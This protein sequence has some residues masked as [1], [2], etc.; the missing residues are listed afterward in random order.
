MFTNL[1]IQKESGLT[2]SK[3]IV[4]LSAR[5]MNYAY[6]IALPLT[7]QGCDPSAVGSCW[8][9][10]MKCSLYCKCCFSSSEM[11]LIFEYDF[12]LIY[13]QYKRNSDLC[14]NRR[15]YAKGEEKSHRITESLRFEKTLRIIKSTHN[16]TRSMVCNY[17][18]CWMYWSVLV[19]AVIK[20][21]QGNS[22]SVC[23]KDGSSCIVCCLLPFFFFFSFFK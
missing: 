3:H 15:K 20:V 14:K 22:P 8:S 9:T 19:S 23:L 2:A 1:I 16:L 4:M 21:P 13:C 12:F 6:L 5:T 10:Q 7:K 18:V 11:L 17:G